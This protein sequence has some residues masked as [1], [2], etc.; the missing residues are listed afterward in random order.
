M[1]RSEGYAG[2]RARRVLVTFLVAAMGWACAPGARAE[3]GGEEYIRDV[4]PPPRASA[5]RRALEEK[6]AREREAAQQRERERQIR[7]QRLQAARTAWEAARPEPA[8][9]IAQHCSRCHAVDLIVPGSRDALGW[10]WTVLRMQLHGA[11]LPWTQ[12]WG[13]IR[14]LVERAQW[15]LPA[16]DPV[17]DDETLLRRFGAE[18]VTTVQRLAQAAPTAGTA[19]TQAREPRSP[20]SRSTSPVMREPVRTDDAPATPAQTL[21]PRKTPPILESDTDARAHKKRPAAPAPIG[22]CDGS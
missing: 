12:V 14:Y 20:R 13:V 7:E 18:G 6:L 3:M 1:T 16:L 17:P 5:D 8:R 2:R 19:D 11:Q 21:V 10:A 9:A 22:L 4:A 15:G